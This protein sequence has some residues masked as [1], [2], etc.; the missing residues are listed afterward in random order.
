MTANQKGEK[1]LKETIIRELK[2]I[3]KTENIK[4]IHAIES[5]SRAWG[6]PSPDSDY[7]VRFI[8]IRP[9]E[10]YLK[11]EKTRDIIEWQLDETLD[12]NGWDIKKALTLIHSSNA[13]L[14]EWIN[15]PIVYSSTVE[16]ELLRPV[17]EEYFSIKSVA[18]HYQAMAK[19]NYIENFTG[20]KVRLK[21]YFYVL[22]PL[23]ACMYTLEK[24]K[25]PPVEFS[26]LLKIPGCKKV[27]EE[28]D[29]LL[30]IKKDTDEKGEIVRSEI[31]D[32][33]IEINLIMLEDKIIN[34]PKEDKPSWDSLDKL[35]LRLSGSIDN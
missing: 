18:S 11:L 27:I 29:R 6:F 14:Y 25:F 21:K 26:E 9:K 4:I 31:L 34:L 10:F 1:T 7:D 13:S 19:K 3:E 15:S 23:M 2:K 12:I 32:N 17:M 33:F 20:E 8:Y 24:K 22:R 5:G 30:E 28:I 16:T 35:F